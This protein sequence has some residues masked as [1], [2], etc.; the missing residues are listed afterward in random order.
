MTVVDIIII[1]IQGLKL[2]KKS[3]RNFATRYQSLVKISQSFSR[4]IVVLHCVVSGVARQNMSSQ[5]LC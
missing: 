3:G 2:R 4:K 5:Y 1:I